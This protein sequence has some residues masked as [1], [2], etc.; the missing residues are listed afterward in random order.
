MGAP[1]GMKPRLLFVV[2]ASGAGK[3]TAVRALERRALP[4]VRCYYFD[5]IGV[6]SA[7]QMEREWGGGDGW[8]ED[9][10]RRWIE[11]LTA[12]NERA[13]VSVLDGQTRHSFIRKHADPVGVTYAVVLLDC[14]APVRERRLTEGR[15][16]PE[17]VT[18]RMEDWADYLRDEAATHGAPIVDTSE[19]SVEAVTDVLQREVERLR[20]LTPPAAV[21]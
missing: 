16:Q 11:R 17:L 14:S 13:A 21:P 4:A 18:H 2:G 19:L 10:T 3:T 20:D 12:D 6:P 9:A 15:A 1:T 5:A 7:E 8:Q